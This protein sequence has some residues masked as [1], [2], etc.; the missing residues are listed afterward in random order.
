MHDRIGWSLSYLHAEVN[1]GR[2]IPWP[3]I[4]LEKTSGVWKTLEFC[5][6]ATSNGSLVTLFQHLLGFI[7]FFCMAK[8][9]LMLRT[10]STFGHFILTDWLWVICSCTWPYCRWIDLFCVVWNVKSGSL[11]HMFLS[12]SSVICYHLS[13][14]DDAC[15][16]ANYPAEI[17]TVCHWVYD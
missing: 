9:M 16:A 10:R 8:V 14:S 7:C 15:W 11:T 3:Q 17:M 13:C 2:I 12:S 5:V 1:L 4:L 6:L